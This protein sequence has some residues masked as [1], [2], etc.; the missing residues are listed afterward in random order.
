MNGCLQMGGLGENGE[1][2]LMR[3]E[4][5]FR[6]QKM[7]HSDCGNGLYTLNICKNHCTL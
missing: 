7:F 5:L 3:M 4:I 2:L 6:G 1:Q